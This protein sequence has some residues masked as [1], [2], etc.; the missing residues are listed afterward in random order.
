VKPVLIEWLVTCCILC[1]RSNC[2]GWC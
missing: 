1:V 2:T